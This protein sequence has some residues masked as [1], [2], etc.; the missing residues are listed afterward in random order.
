MKRERSSKKLKIY[1]SI[2]IYFFFSVAFAFADD[3]KPITHS[4]EIGLETILFDYEEEDNTFNMSIDGP[5]YGLHGGYAFHAE[6]KIMIGVSLEYLFGDLEYENVRRDG[7]SL[8]ADSDDWIVEFRGLVGYDFDFGGRHVVT[9][10]IGFGYRYWNDDVDTMG[11]YEREIE[12]WYS[13]I[14]IKTVSPLSDDWT[15]G[16]G[17]EYDLFLGG[18]VKSH[19]SD[20]LAGYNDPEVDLDLG[21]GYG[22]RLSL[23][24]RRAFN[25]HYALSIKP[26]I[27]YW[28]IDRSSI[29]TLNYYGAPILYIWEPEN[30]TTAYGLRLSFEF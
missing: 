21:D 5:M 17:V 14:G 24:F 23:H 3:I 20:V 4:F 29:E 25:K 11:A 30:E 26:Y 1:F 27:R 7:T 15:W 18:K 9:P 16:V 22:L 12:Y 19:F 6:N 2:V 28:N 10:F 13:P 8:S